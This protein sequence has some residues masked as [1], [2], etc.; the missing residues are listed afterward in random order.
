MPEEIDE[1]LLKTGAVSRKGNSR[2][3]GYKPGLEPPSPSRSD[4]RKVDRPGGRSYPTN[5]ISFTAKADQV[6]DLRE[7]QRH[8]EDFGAKGSVTRALA[9]K[10]CVIYTLKALRGEEADLVAIANDLK[11]RY[12]EP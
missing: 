2:G 1:V 9:Y 10:S 7:V 5:T 8:L 6:R 11:D 12:G 3:H 4:D